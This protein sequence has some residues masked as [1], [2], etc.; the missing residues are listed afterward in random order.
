MFGQPPR[1]GIFPGV[2]GPSVK[3][4]DV[5]DIV[6]EDEEVNVLQY[7]C[8]GKWQEDVTVV[9]LEMKA[10]RNVVKDTVVEDILLKD[11]EDVE[12]WNPLENKTGDQVWCSDNSQ[13]E[14]RC[15]NDDEMRFSDDDQA[16]FN[17]EKK[18]TEDFQER[19]SGDDQ[20]NCRNDG[21]EGDSEE[22]PKNMMKVGWYSQR[23]IEKSQAQW[24]N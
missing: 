22:E 20:E 12:Q 10:D 23:K 14:E 21:V 4:E 1:Q 24:K 13:L 18:C 16:R 2:K 7:Q 3:V 5:E 6:K 19:C 8:S 15:N 17:E 9:S 11:E